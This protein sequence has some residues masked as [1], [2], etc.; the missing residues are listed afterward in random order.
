MQYRV[1]FLP[2]FANA[3]AL[4]LPIVAVIAGIAVAAILWKDVPMTP[5]D[6]QLVLA[7]LAAALVLTAFMS[8]VSE[9]FNRYGVDSGGITCRTAAGMGAATLILKQ[10][11]AVK[12]ENIVEAR[13][14]RW[15]PYRAVALTVERPSDGR[16]VRITLPLYVKDQQALLRDLSS[17]APN[18]HPLRLALGL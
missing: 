16:R 1:H 8:S 10:S 12:W 3:L 17:Y 13:T 5:K 9:L 6:W 4:H 11:R 15:L 7:I 2:A 18:R 14:L